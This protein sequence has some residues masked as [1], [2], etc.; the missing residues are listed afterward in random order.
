MKRTIVIPSALP[1][2]QDT[3]SLKAFCGSLMEWK[4]IMPTDRSTNT[5][6]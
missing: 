4:V 5:S 1:E 2:T 6:A 3:A